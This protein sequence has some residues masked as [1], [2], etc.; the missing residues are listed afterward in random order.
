M[1]TVARLPLQLKEG[2]QMCSTVGKTVT[3][4]QK[5]MQELD[6]DIVWPDRSHQNAS[7]SDVA[8]QTEPTANNEDVEALKKD[9]SEARQQH[10]TEKHNLTSVIK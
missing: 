9:L 5:M 10:E 8:L 1:D 4:V 3:S 2:C 6:D 7:S